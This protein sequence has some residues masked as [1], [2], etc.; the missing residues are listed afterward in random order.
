MYYFKNWSISLKI[1]KLNPESFIRKLPVC[2]MTQ[3][4][5]D[6]IRFTSVLTIYIVKIKKRFLK[7]L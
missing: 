4:G 7:K 2:R 3:I 5:G 1:V 6:I